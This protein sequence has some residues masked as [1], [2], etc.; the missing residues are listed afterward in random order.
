MAGPA[1]AEPSGPKKKNKDVVLLF[2][3]KLKRIK[4]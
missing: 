2:A 4:K 3:Q 1:V